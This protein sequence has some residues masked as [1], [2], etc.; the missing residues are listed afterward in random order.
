M[1]PLPYHRHDPVQR[2]E[3]IGRVR[4]TTRWL[5]AGS[6]LGTGVLVGVV[7]HEL[8]GKSA[9]TSSGSNS[10]GSASSGSG[11]GSSG[12]STNSSGSN[13]GSSIGQPSFSAPVHASS[14]GS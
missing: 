14:G 3:A 6:L 10:S 12:S 4:R 1:P 2:D 11:N 13:G 7:A 9:S 5:I 8:P